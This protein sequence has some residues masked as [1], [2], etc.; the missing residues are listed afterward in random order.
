[1]SLRRAAPALAALVPLAI[2]LAFVLAFGVDIPF[3]DE[4]NMIAGIERVFDG[5]LSLADLWHHHNEHVAFFD[6]V[7]IV[8]LAYASRW[9]LRVLMLGAIAVTALSLLLLASVF[10][11]V[12][13]LTPWATALASCFLFSLHAIENWLWGGQIQIALAVLGGIG[14]FALLSRATLRW[15][16]VAAAVLF[17]FLASWSF[18]AGFLAWPLGALLLALRT[19]ADAG[20]RKGALVAW[21]AGAAVAIGLPLA[22]YPAR[23]FAPAAAF[24][25]ARMAD[26]VACYAGAGLIGPIDDLTT[27]R[28]AGYPAIAILLLGGLWIAIRRRGSPAALAVVAIGLFGLGTGCMIALGRGSPSFL[29]AA[30]A[31]RY[32]SFAGLCWIAAALMPWLA[33]EGASRRLR[34]V[35]A[36]FAL[37]VVAVLVVSQGPRVAEG[38]ETA[39]RRARAAEALR[40]GEGMSLDV[41]SAAFDQPAGWLP[42]LHERLAVLRRHRLSFFRD[43]SPAELAP[44]PWA[45]ALTGT[46]AL[47]GPASRPRA[48]I[49][50]RGGVPGN[51]AM[52]VFT[53]DGVPVTAPLTLDASGAATGTIE[54][55]PEPFPE[56]ATFV[57]FSLD[58]EGRIIRSAPARLRR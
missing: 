53:R 37:A 49:E 44:P 6:H 41:L 50:A 9:D 52:A 56:D 7:A 21:L 4:W 8:S 25:L 55:G 16:A 35:R 31:S 5:N 13:G 12:E 10:R 38:R 26:F 36:A 33:F 23:G 15:P 30:S 45:G 27:A 46:L 22:T 2:A 42:L 32:A 51:V 1:M 24:S 3:H 18:L 20:S 29:Q 48:T 34:T 14:A 47:G 57:V 58:R 54:V 43:A 40:A 11:R 39:Q 28:L 17:A 19:P